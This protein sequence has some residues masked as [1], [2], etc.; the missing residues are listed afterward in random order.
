VSWTHLTHIVMLELILIS[1][2]ILSHFSTAV[3]NRKK[4]IYVEVCEK[5]D[6]MP[7]HIAKKNLN[8]VVE[9]FVKAKNYA[10][11]DK[12]WYLKRGEQ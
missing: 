10:L 4:I 8:T 5:T 1:K 11:F 6:K 7:R 12:F 3:Q 9:T 2:C